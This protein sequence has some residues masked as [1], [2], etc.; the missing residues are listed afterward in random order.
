MKNEIV[1]F[2]DADVFLLQEKRMRLMS[3]FP[4]KV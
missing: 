3:V 2:T 4:T 1:L